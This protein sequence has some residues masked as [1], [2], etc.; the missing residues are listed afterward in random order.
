MRRIMKEL[1]YLLPS[2]TFSY[3]DE[4]GSTCSSCCRSWEEDHPSG[5]G[6]SCCIGKGN[7]HRKGVLD[8]ASCTSPAVFFSCRYDRHYR[9]TIDRGTLAQGSP[10]LRT[11]GPVFFTP[12]ASSYSLLPL[13]GE[14]EYKRK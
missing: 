2:S 13:Q 4:R 7:E 12:S 1:C 5:T 9:C 14:E 11:S 3:S 10:A 8:G 6:Y